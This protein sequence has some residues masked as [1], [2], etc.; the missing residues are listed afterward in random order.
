[1]TP[2]SRVGCN[3]DPA[4]LTRIQP[5]NLTTF[6]AIDDHV[7]RAP[8]EMTEHRVPARGTVDE[9]VG[10]ILATRQGN[11]KSA[12]LVGAHG[13]DDVGETVHIDQHAETACATEQWMTFQPTR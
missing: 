12:F 9:P 10:W 5:V 6:A 7:P 13:V 11:P 4:Q 2:R 3:G 1:M 8:V